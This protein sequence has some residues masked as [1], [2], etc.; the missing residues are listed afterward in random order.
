MPRSA[1]GYMQLKQ[2]M[3]R[4]GQSVWERGRNRSPAL[5]AEDLALSFG[6]TQ[7][8]TAQFQLQ[9][10]QQA[11]E[12]EKQR[13]SRSTE[14]G[15]NFLKAWTSS[16]SDVKNIFNRALNALDQPTTTYGQPSGTT[17]MLNNLLSQIQTQYAEWQKSYGG[18]DTEIASALSGTIQERQQMADL[19]KQLTTPDYEG[20]AAEAG[21]QA[22]QE[23]AKTR[24][25]IAREALSYGIDPSSGKFGA[26]TR[27]TAL[28]ESKNVIGAMNQARQLEKERVQGTALGAMEAFD[29]TVFANIMKAISDRSSGFL[30]A[31]TDIAKTIADI[32]IAEQVSKTG[33]A[34]AIGNIAGS[35]AQSILNPLGDFAGY[36][37]AGGQ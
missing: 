11:W 17:D 30:G 37:L 20:V 34:Q 33:R 10:Q 22:R 26:L 36:Y 13:A 5:T 12:I 28:E 15:N 9:Q 3:A 8:K 16:M 14:L 32:G 27:R 1:M 21:I 25:D 29:P 2:K 23:A 31:Q 35:Y 4:S 7:L 19:I 6:Q 24:E 18:L